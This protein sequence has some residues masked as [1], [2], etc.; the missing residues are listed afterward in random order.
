MRNIRLDNNIPTRANGYRTVTKEKG[1]KQ[2]RC[3]HPVFA[4]PFQPN[5]IRHPHYGD[6][7]SIG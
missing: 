6:A 4:R 5:M 3:L 7:K 2:S 1:A